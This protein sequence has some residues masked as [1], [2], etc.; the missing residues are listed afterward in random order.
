MIFRQVVSSNQEDSQPVLRFDEK[1]YPFQ[2]S[3]DQN[4][5]KSLAWNQPLVKPLFIYAFI[6]Y[7]QNHIIIFGHPFL[8]KQCCIGKHRG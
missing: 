2:Q 4:N 1:F 6:C 3:C 7:Y 8:K 5:G